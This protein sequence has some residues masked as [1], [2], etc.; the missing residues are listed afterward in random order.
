MPMSTPGEDA[1]HVLRYRRP[2]TVWT[3]ALPVGNGHRAAMCEG[4]PLGERLHLNDG[5]AW[6]GPVPEGLLAG[7]QDSGVEA[8]ATLRTAIDSGDLDRAEQLA[9]RQQTPW[10]QAFLPFGTV[11]IALVDQIGSAVVEKPD[12]AVDLE[13]TLDLRTGIAAHTYAMAG[14]GRMQHET[15]AD[16]VTGALTHRIVAEAP[17]RLEVRVTG[18]FPD[19]SAGSAPGNARGALVAHWHLPVDVPPGHAEPPAEIRYDVER[20]RQG[21]VVIHAST[22]SDNTDGVLRTE[23]AREHLLLIGTAT[24]DAGTDVV[25]LAAAVASAGDS[26]ASDA[27]ALRAAH[28][29]AHRELYDRCALDLPVTTEVAALDT[30]ERIIRAQGVDDPALSALSFHYGRYLLMS[31]SRPGGLPANLQGIWNAELP[32]PWSS[33]YTTNINLEMAYWP[34]ETTGLAECHEPLLDFIGR[35]SAGAG[36]TVARELYGADGWVLH[37][38]TDPWGHAAAVGQGAGDPAWS[39]WPMGGVWLSLHLWEHARF[40][41]ADQDGGDTQWLAST[42]WPVLERTAHFAL[43]W[44]QTDGVRAW[45]SP[46]T[47][48]EHGWVDAGGT[49]RPLGLMASMDAELLR[50]LADACTEAAAILDRDDAWVVEFAELVALLPPLSVDARGR[51]QEWV[52]DVP[53][54]EPHHRHLSHLVGLF[55]LGLITPD[56]TPGLAEAAAR[57]ILGRGPESTGWALAWRALMWARLHD[58][59]RVYEQ[60]RMLLRSAHGSD[61]AAHRGGVYRNLFSAHPPFQIDGNLGFTAAV[62]EALVQS[63]E[64]VIDVLPALPSAWPEGSVRGIRARGGVEVDVVWAAGR[65]SR[66]A[67]RSARAR[68]VRLRGPGLA[69]RTVELVPG[70]QTNVE[71]AHEPVQEKELSW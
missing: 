56:A 26:D 3:D 43:S 30:D 46:S 52:S 65:M 36:A 24:A 12:S 63:H 5:S 49:P 23:A 4:R 59:E 10:A 57:S 28:I 54:A 41:G 68:E 35:V 45:T 47:S 19:A 58:G 13:R 9:M 64:G 17:V 34:A 27:A 16:A 69:E 25:A 55:P 14:I 2:S 53:D 62:A 44:V 32:G 51:I 71:A 70:R 37:H 11:D 1:L 29:A 15:W 6:S 48:P 50:A 60:L 42:A 61:T 38:N 20:G 67:L 18:P 7:A 40:S 8:L 31:S 39:T 66:I 33:G 21:A 22:A